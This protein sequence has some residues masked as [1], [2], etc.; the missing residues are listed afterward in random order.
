LYDIHDQAERN[1]R[2]YA[3]IGIYAY[4]L[5]EAAGLPGRIDARLDLSGIPRIQVIGTDHRG[6]APSGGLYPLDD[7]RF[8]A[9]ITHLENMDCLRPLD[10]FSE[11]MFPFFNFDLWSIG[12]LG[13]N[14]PGVQEGDQQDAQ[15]Y[16][17][18]HTSSSLRIAFFP[19]SHFAIRIP[20]SKFV[21]ATAPF[22]SGRS[23]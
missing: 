13:R 12:T 8:L 4:V 11:I 7:Q 16:Y 14:Q 1:H 18:F 3:V 10:D 19:A 21:F 22:F 17:P 9:C 5:F 15:P 23:C 6:G 2:V 20:H